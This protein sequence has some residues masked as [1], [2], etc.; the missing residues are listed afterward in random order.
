[1]ILH[2]YKTVDVHK[3]CM[4]WFL[5]EGRVGDLL[6]WLCCHAPPNIF[7]KSDF[8]NWKPAFDSPRPATDFC[9]AAVA[10]HRL[11]QK[12]VW[13]E[14][15]TCEKC[16]PMCRSTRSLLYACERGLPWADTDTPVLRQRAFVSRAA[17]GLDGLLKSPSPSGV[18]FPKNWLLCSWGVMPK[19]ISPSVTP[20]LG[21]SCDIF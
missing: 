14:Q 10:L 17:A 15:V 21:S 19:L 12:R 1:M 18:H 4:V 7:E 8:F 6:S 11:Q 13:R 16:V 9:F 2:P 3:I 5:L 20:W